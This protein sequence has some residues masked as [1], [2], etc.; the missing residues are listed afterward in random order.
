MAAGSHARP[1]LVPVTVQLLNDL[2]HVYTVYV[3]D[4]SHYFKPNLYSDH[5]YS[6]IT[7]ALRDPTVDARSR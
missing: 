2:K 7:Q 3:E 6:S 4:A 5:R 1:D